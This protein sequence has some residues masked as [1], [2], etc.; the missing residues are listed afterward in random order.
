[1]IVAP[2]G[3]KVFLSAR[4]RKAQRKAAA[5]AEAALQA[6]H[7]EQKAEIRACANGYGSVPGKGREQGKF[8]QMKVYARKD[9]RVGDTLKVTA[10]VDEWVRRRR[11]GEEVVRGLWCDESSGGKVGM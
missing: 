10:R 6:L 3:T 5:E 4:E 11:E 1:M 2:D 7:A 8:S 9:V